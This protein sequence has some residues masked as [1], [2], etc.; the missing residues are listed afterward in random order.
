LLAGQWINNGAVAKEPVGFSAL[1]VGQVNIFSIPPSV[2]TVN[3]KFTIV[4]SG[5]D[6]GE[7]GFHVFTGILVCVGNV[8]VFRVFTLDLTNIA[9]VGVGDVILGVLVILEG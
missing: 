5:D 8:G 2:A 7:F 9:L 3:G 4:F 1:G 6:L